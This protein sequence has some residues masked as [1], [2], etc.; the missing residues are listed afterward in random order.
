MFCCGGRL[1]KNPQRKVA[2]VTPPAA[3]LLFLE[4]RYALQ[5]ATKLQSLYKPNADMHSALSVSPASLMCCEHYQ[6]VQNSS[7]CRQR[8]SQSLTQL[9]LLQHC[10]GERICQRT[11]GDTTIDVGGTH[12]GKLA[13]RRDWSFDV[14]WCCRNKQASNNK[15][16]KVRRKEE[17]QRRAEKRDK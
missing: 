9:H 16:N 1:I 14:T 15:K 13:S 4:V 6:S 2:Q 12:A 3:A 8:Q 11:L 5:L 7:Y 17:K 10:Q